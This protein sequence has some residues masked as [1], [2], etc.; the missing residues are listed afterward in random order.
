MKAARYTAICIL[1]ICNISAITMSL[2]F[3]EYSKLM[4]RGI[5]QD[6]VCSDSEVEQVTPRD[7]LSHTDHMTESIGTVEQ[8]SDY[9]AR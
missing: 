8:C 5:S 6:T 3:G 2:T 9:P 1:C 4:T 7:H